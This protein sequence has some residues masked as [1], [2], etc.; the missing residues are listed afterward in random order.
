MTHALQMRQMQDFESAW[1]WLWGEVFLFGANSDS[2]A[3]LLSL[4][5]LKH[6]FPEG[7]RSNCASI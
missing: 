4:V 2:S 6:R 1:R 3:N 5:L 7:G